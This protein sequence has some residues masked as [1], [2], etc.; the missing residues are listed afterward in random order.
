MTDLKTPEPKDYKT[1]ESFEVDYDKWVDQL[2]ESDDD[3]GQCE[4]GFINA[5]EIWDQY[6]SELPKTKSLKPTFATLFMGGGGADKGLE[7]AGFESIWGIERDPKIAEVARLNFPNT[8]V[9][10]SCV[11]DINPRSL[12]HVNLLWMSP[13]CQQYS[14]A[15]RG[16]LG[17]HKDKDA[18]LY[19]S[20][21]IAAIDPRWVVLE[22]VPS[23]SK[24]PVFEKIL[25][26]LIRNGYRYHWL[27]LDAADHGVPQ[28]RKRLILW[29]VKNSEPL[30]YFPES[31]PRLG[32]YQA[33]ADLIPEMQDCELADWQIKR[34]NE[35]GYLPEKAL[36]DISE[37]RHKPAT[38]RGGNDPSFTLLTGHCNSHSP[39]L[40]IP[41]AGANI[42]NFTPSQ[43][44]DPCFTIRAMTSGRH[45]HWA[46]IVQGSQI[47]RINQRATAR[48]QT[49]PDD[50]K[51]PEST[52]LTQQ[53]IGNA[54]PPL[55]AKELG[56][57]ILKS[58]NHENN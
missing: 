54:V 49:F 53:I 4:E 37:N 38:V 31:K 57:A 13:P 14:N 45:T 19:C 33:I 7:F 23:Y 17:D 20:S 2:W 6:Q 34:L 51:F 28:N 22:N 24:S 43:K 8:K 11:G 9:F 21:Y 16:N 18:G 41:R 44:D 12:P 46:D 52:S 50:Y 40:L 36:I 47:K 10:N 3:V 26:S 29:A 35:L 32:W 30:P 48:L 1:F 39:V 42:Q 27:I 15:R 55:L 5:E 58:I 25:Q 56:L